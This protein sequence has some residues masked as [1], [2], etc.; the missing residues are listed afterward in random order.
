MSTRHDSMSNNHQRT[1]LVQSALGREY[2]EI[3]AKQF[4]SMQMAKLVNTRTY[5]MMFSTW[6]E[7]R[8]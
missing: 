7:W 6:F 5:R 1:D 3:S 2:S 4:M 8:V